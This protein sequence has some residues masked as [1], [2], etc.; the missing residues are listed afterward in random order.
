MSKKSATDKVKA[1]AK[2]KIYRIEKEIKLHPKLAN[3][4]I[5]MERL[6][7]WKGKI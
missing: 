3:N 2:R 1:T 4:A 6:T 5:L 7:F